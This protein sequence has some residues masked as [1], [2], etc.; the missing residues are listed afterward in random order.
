MAAQILNVISSTSEQDIGAFENTVKKFHEAIRSN[1]PN[2]SISPTI[3]F[4]ICHGPAVMRYLG[5]RTG[6]LS[7]EAQERTNKI[8]RAA[9]LN[10]TRKIG[11][12]SV[13]EDLSHWLYQRS[14]PLLY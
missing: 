9:R 11:P 10:H 3:H 13:M 2:I 1:F 6:H 12:L 5:N 7:E 14:D 8:L 4:V